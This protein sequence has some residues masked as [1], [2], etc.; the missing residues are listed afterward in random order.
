MGR[1]GGFGSFPIWP[2][3]VAPAWKAVIDGLKQRHPTPRLFRY[4]SAILGRSAGSGLF[5]IRPIAFS[6]EAIE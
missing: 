5:F 3:G 4:F 1:L 2:A 6:D